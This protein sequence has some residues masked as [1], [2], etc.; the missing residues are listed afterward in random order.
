MQTLVIFNIAEIKTLI[1][2]DLSLTGLDKNTKDKL[3]QYWVI[4][5]IN[6]YRILPMQNKF[7]PNE[8]YENPLAYIHIA[9]DRLLYK[10]LIPY[11]HKVNR[12][13]KSVKLFDNGDLLV[14]FD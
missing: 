6:Q 3:I 5:T 10:L 1:L 13:V 9:Y 11:T 2:R 12:E 14:Y 4:F 8:L 7:I